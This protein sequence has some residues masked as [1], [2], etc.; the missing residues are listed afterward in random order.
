MSKQDS[1]PKGDSSQWLVILV[2]GIL[3][4]AV[5]YAIWQKLS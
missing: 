3:L 4:A 1:A 5:C 2:L